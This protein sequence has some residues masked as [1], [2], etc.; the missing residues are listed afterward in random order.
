MRDIVV[1]NDDI[2]QIMNLRKTHFQQ[3]YISMVH[4]Y[5]KS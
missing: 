5:Q 1:T 2:E 3:K 4:N